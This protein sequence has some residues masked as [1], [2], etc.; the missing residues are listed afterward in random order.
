MAQKF[1]FPGLISDLKDNIWLVLSIVQT[2]GIGYFKM[3]LLIGFCAIF[4][5]HKMVYSPIKKSYS[6][7]NGMIVVLT[8]QQQNAQSYT[9]QQTLLAGLASRMQPLAQKEDFLIGTIN[10]VC[11]SLHVVPETIG[12][13]QDAV[14]AGLPLSNVTLRMRVPFRMAAEVVARFEHSSK[15]LAVTNVKVIRADS[16][17]QVDMTL[18]LSTVFY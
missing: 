13:A 5:V 6:E 11:N 2:K 14:V 4:G 16:L 18:S 7:K 9:Q 3:P 15:F 8:A 1:D 10:Q 17:R 12:E